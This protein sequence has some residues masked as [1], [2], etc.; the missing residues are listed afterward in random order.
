MSSFLIKKL[1]I[2]AMCF[3]G[4]YLITVIII[5]T[6]YIDSYKLRKS[7][8]FQR[9]TLQIN[10]ANSTNLKAPNIFFSASPISIFQKL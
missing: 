6:G 1:D 2:I 3:L 7:N 4:Y 10:L 9:I 5:N 8:L